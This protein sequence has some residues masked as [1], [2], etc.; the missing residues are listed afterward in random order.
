MP[1]SRPR[2]GETTTRPS[3]PIVRS[4]ARTVHILEALFYAPEGK[5][6]TELSRQLGL[7]KV[8]ALRLLRTLEREGVVQQDRATGAYRMDPRA[9]L[10]AASIFNRLYSAASAVQG[11]LD[12]LAGSTHSTAMLA[13][14][15][16]AQRSMTLAVRSLPQSE[17]LAR[18]RDLAPIHATASGKC[19]LASLP[20]D[21]VREWVAGGLPKV[22]NHTIASPQ[23]LLEEIARV[24]AQ[25][26]CSQQE[27]LV[28]GC[29]SLAVPVRDSAG[30]F[31]AALELVAPLAHLTQSSMVRQ[32][33]R[34]LRQAATS[35]SGALAVPLADLD[36]A[37]SARDQERQR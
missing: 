11:T 5:R 27:Q 4:A 29:V 30:S 24:R 15:V 37:P 18:P 6:L 7:H 32:Y 12:A 26:Y 16:E 20:E 19:Y 3:M 36:P 22:T 9:W 14:P 17:L 2:R 1:T 33:L 28:P 35:L 34:P 23:R 10:P 31:T 8:T 21:K 25:G 13:F